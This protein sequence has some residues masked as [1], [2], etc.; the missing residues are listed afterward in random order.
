MNSNSNC[1]RSRA[2]RSSRHSLR[3]Q[4]D[5]LFKC[6]LPENS[7]V[8]PVKPLITIDQQFMGLQNVGGLQPRC[9]QLFAANMC[10]AVKQ[11]SLARVLLCGWWSAVGGLSR[12]E[13]KHHKQQCSSAKFPQTRILVLPGLPGFQWLYVQTTCSRN[14]F[15]GFCFKS[16]FRKRPKREL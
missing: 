10:F 15:A 5:M 12:H 14:V 9:F 8:Q 16:T 7:K 2:R 6:S 3:R 4:T 11:L 13:P 1:P